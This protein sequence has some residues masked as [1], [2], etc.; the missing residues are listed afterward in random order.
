MNIDQELF[1]GDYMNVIE[2]L[3]DNKKAIITEKELEGLIGCRDYERFAREVGEMVKQNIIC[4]VKT[5]KSGTNGRIP[6]LYNRYRVI[7]SGNDY[8]KAIEE[9]KLLNPR[10][11]ISGY[12]EKPAVYEKYKEVVD[13]LS[14]YLWKQAELLIEPMS[15]NERSFSVWGFEKLLGQNGAIVADILKFNDINSEELNYFNTPE[16]FIEYVHER[17]SPMNVLI[18]EN[19]DTW[20]SFRKVM[21]ETGKNRFLD[22]DIHV[23]LYGEGRK[24]TRKNGRIDEY[25]A[26]WN[27]NNNNTYYYFGDLDYE[28][29]QIYFDL[30][31]SNTTTDIRLFR[32]AYRMVK[33]LA[34]GR[35]LPV[36]KDGRNKT[37]RYNEFLEYFPKDVGGPMRLILESGRYIPQEILNYQII[38][39]NMR[40][41]TENV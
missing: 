6:P 7:R 16:P 4:P 2:R 15:Q 10:L 30:K 9:I 36:S 29:I 1:K 19:K 20:F 22:V 12:L 34:N 38:K 17:T 32:D 21:L 25:D 28:G 3:S 18:I 31:A 14:D 23:L 33:R 27:H 37:G 24:I 13:K 11:N 39:K 35:I 8:S 41:T 40:G 5:K 26:Q